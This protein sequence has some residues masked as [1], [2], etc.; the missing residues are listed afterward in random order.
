MKAEP[1]SVGELKQHLLAMGSAPDETASR[2]SSL[3][4]AGRDVPEN[5][6]IAARVDPADG[7]A[8]SGV[9]LLAVVFDFGEFWHRKG[10]RRGDRVR[11]F[12]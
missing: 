2:Q 4:G 5:A 3:D 6:R 8:E 7:L 9:P 11:P 1:G 10:I 12:P